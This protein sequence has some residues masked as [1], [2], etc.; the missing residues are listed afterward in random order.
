MENTKIYAEVLEDEAMEQFKS[1]IA[2][3][4]SV[5]GALMP[6]AH[7]GYS[8][9]IGA[10]VATDGFIYPAW[11]G[12]DIGCGMCA[13]QLKGIQR[14]DIEMFREDIFNGIYKSIPVGF[15]K[16]QHSTDYSLEGL[17]GDGMEIAMSNKGLQQ[18]IQ[19]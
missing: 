10:V 9:P 8:L 7:T 3:P 14:L 4:Y 1:A 17:T 18:G 11:V 5:S 12:Y 13:I 6:D 15:S 16:N 19:G 2:Q